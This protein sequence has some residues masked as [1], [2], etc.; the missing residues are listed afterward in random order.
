MGRESENKIPDSLLYTW[1][2]KNIRKFI[3]H[4]QQMDSNGLENSKMKRTR[5]YGNGKNLFVHGCRWK[6]H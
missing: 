3:R 2:L 1:R 4:K 5:G 6:L